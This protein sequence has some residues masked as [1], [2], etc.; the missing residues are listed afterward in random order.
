M[1]SPDSPV[2]VVGAGPTGLMMALQLASRGVKPLII[3][4]HAGPVR[5]TRAL[6]VQARTLEIYAHAGV[7][8]R[9][10]EL[11]MRAT[12]GNLWAEGRKKARLPL[13]DIGK[14]LSPYPYLLILG[15]D[16]NEKILGEALRPH[17][18]D[19]E[20]NT[21]LIGLRQAE[22]HVAVDLKQAD[23]TLRTLRVEWV[24]GCDGA[25]S[26]V[27]HLNAIDFPGAP[28][29]HVF[30]VADIVA[31]GPMVQ[32]ELNIY[33]WREGFHL[34]FPMRG[35][36]H[37]RLVGIVPQELRGR[38]GVTFDDVA[39]AFLAEAGPGFRLANC[40]WFSTYRIHHRRAA[41][42]QAG[43]CL[44]LGDAAHIHSPVGAQG[45]NTGL[46]DAYNL[47]WKLASTILKRSSSDLVATYAIERE[48]VAKRLLE[49][50]DLAFTIA[51]SDNWLAQSF[52]T[53]IVGRLASLALRVPAV[54]RL[55]FRTISQIGIEYRA[56]PL[57]VTLPGWPDKTP[58]AGDRLPWCTLRMHGAATAQDVFDVLD[59][60]QFHLLTIG[61]AGANEV[62]TTDD[63]I[64][65]HKVAD[66]A[67][68]HAEL[69]RVGI[70]RTAMLLVRPDGHLAM[71]GT[72][73]SRED[74]VDYFRTRL[75]Q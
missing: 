40:T 27:R 25:R 13:G 37:W 75:N 22:D 17:G 21:E 70:P 72:H 41:R 55:A 14:G 48:P 67:D 6:G 38:E 18:V 15:Q 29:E 62:P 31:T 59:D 74:I 8:E 19:V 58:Q 24:A 26:A 33:F 39:H 12:G 66:H 16:D 4:R 3:D 57:S 10:L 65:I 7:I 35:A 23:G 49:T 5:E 2:L 56:S 68:N 20:W 34:M 32:G 63:R 73:L 54:Q 53:Q 44:L 42:F 52:R 64:R 61:D 50:T 28:Y 9:A 43:R 11:G 46:Q 60:K 71:A 1:S 45:M 51:I 30:F 69:D 36:D 47:G